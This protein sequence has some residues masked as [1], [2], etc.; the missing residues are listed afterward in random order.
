[1]TWPLGSLTLLRS[2]PLQEGD[3]V[4]VDI[5]VFLDGYHGDTSQT[6]L[7]GQVVRT[8][9]NQPTFSHA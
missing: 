1:M 5:T 4:N 6:F 9:P 2:R 3:I 7:V 8:R